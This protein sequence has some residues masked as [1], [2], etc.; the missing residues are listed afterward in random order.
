[1]SF[2][3]GDPNDIPDLIIAVNQPEKHGSGL[4]AYV[5][6]NVVTKTTRTAFDAAE[7]S[8]RRR[9]QDFLWLH[10]RLTENFP[11]VI[12]PPLPEKQ[13]L[14]RLDRFT[15]EFIHLRQ[16]ALEKFLV[17][18][19]KHEKLT[20]CDELKTFLTAKAWEL[21]SAKKQT[22]GL[23]NKVGGR[24]EQVK[25]YASSIKI[26]NRNMD[27]V[28]MHDYVVNLSEKLTQID[29]ISQ[30]ISKDQSDLMDQ[31]SEYAPVFLNWA[32]SEH[33]LADSLTALSKCVDK[34]NKALKELVESRDE[35]FGENLHEYVLFTESIKTTLRKRDRIQVQ[36]DQLVEQVARKTENKRRLNKQVDASGEK[37]RDADDT[38]KAEYD[39]W[40]ET[41]RSDL[42]ATFIDFADRNIV[43]FQKVSQIG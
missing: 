3:S 40:N 13:V 34:N 19:A 15:P 32:N 25:N 18:V 43:Y 38:V 17:R 8:V 22:S 41:K 7:Y 35:K 20:N 28:L 36:H 39:K 5:S 42:K 37:M 27:F 6:Y 29:R 10:T 21:T 14:K 11:L 30:R 2:G 26:K 12:I 9:Y 1:M 31:Q 23:I 4:D 16:L 24:I 33:R